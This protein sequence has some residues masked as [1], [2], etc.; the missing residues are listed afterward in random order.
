MDDVDGML[1]HRL[2]PPAGETPEST[3]SG[4]ALLRAN[5]PGAE[6]K[7]GFCA[8]IDAVSGDYEGC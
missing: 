4:Y 7:P 6:P 8:V 5:T 1:L 2:V 3:E